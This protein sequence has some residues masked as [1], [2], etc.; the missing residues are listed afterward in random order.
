MGT[1][2]WSPSDVSTSPIPPSPSVTCAPISGAWRK[3]KLIKTL[4][5]READPTLADPTGY[6]ISEKVASNVISECETNG[7]VFLNPTKLALTTICQGV[8]SVC[9]DGGHAHENW[10]KVDVDRCHEAFWRRTVLHHMSNSSL[11]YRQLAA[12][13]E[14]GD[15][16]V[17]CLEEEPINNMKE[18]GLCA[19]GGVG[20]F[21][22]LCGTAFPSIQER[23][24]H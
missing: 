17:C 22:C 3:A 10:R 20:F 8:I 7:E 2:V 11:R 4:S 12:K 23:I 9:H 6:R 1:R 5:L 18:C 14:G 19:V 16:E 13:E 21:C 15:I 24:A